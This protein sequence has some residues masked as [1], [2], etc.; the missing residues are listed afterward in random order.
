MGDLDFLVYCCSYH[1]SLKG[2]LQEHVKMP[3]F[4]KVLCTDVCKIVTSGIN[5]GKPRTLDPLQSRP[6]KKNFHGLKIDK[7]LT[8]SKPYPFHHQL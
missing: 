8:T 1:Y 6:S 5:H 4:T 7:L 2:L 3:R